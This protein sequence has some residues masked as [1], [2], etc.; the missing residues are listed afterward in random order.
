MVELSQ[1][2]DDVR[3]KKNRVDQRGGP[4][5]ALF[6]DFP[7]IDDRKSPSGIFPGPSHGAD[8]EQYR[9]QLIHDAGTFLGV[10][11]STST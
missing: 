1:L 7:A 2:D 5:R 3:R 9:A 6:P 4:A 10:A 8:T 11:W